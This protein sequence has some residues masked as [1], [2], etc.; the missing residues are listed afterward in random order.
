[1]FDILRQRSAWGTFVGLFCSSYLLYLLV[2]WLPFYLV[3]E[4]RFS[5][6]SMAK[7]GGGM[8]LLQALCSTIC[9][10]LSDRWIAAGRTPTMVH[11]TSTIVGVLGAGASLVASSLVG[12][13]LSVTL[14]LVVGI[15]LG[16]SIPSLWPMTQRLAGPHAS[17]RWTGLQCAFGNLSGA[18][19][20]AV[21]GLVLD[22]TGHFLWAFV[23]AAGFCCIGAL[24]WIF[25]VGQ[26]EPVQWERRVPVGV[27][28]TTT[29]LA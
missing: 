9:G 24:N 3:R 6:D 11:K 29:E 15:S 27:A 23:I 8:F 10:R 4:R 1:V 7:I 25:V 12:D 2:A 14:L 22:R 28:Q 20:S 26:I 21:T 17:G 18:L 13:V 5:M 16:M 19:G